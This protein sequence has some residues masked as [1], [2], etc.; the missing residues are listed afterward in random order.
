MSQ[1]IIPLLDSLLSRFYDCFLFLHLRYRTDYLS[2]SHL[3]S[4]ALENDMMDDDEGTSECTS[5]ALK[6]S[7]ETRRYSDKHQ[8]KMLAL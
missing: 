4:V 1:F 7:I 2:M 8:R 6:Y 5:I 3:S